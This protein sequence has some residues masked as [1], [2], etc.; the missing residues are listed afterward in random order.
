MKRTTLFVMLMF[1]ALVLHSQISLTQDFDNGDQ[2]WETNTFF[3]ISINPCSGVSARK[4]I[5]SPATSGDMTSPNLVGLSNGN[6]VTV[7][8][9][10]KIVDWGLGTVATQPGWGDFE[11]Q[12]STDDG[13][14]WITVVTI[15]DSNHIT[16]NQCANISYNISGSSLPVG[17]DFKFRINATYAD[18]DYF[19]YI[20]NIVIS[21]AGNQSPPVNDDVQDAISLDVGA[22][23]DDFKIDGSVLGATM[24]SE[25]AGC[26][27]DG[28]GVWYKTIVPSDGAVLIETG[29]HSSN[30][31]GFDSVIEVFSGSIGSLVSI[32]CNDE[33]DNT[34]A[35][36]SQLELTSLTPGETVYIRVWEDG[37]NETEPFAISAYAA[38]L[39]TDEFT[40]DD[41]NLYPNPMKDF[42]KVNA[43]TT[44]DSLTIYDVLGKK[45]RQ[46]N[47]INP[48]TE[49]DI[50]NLKSGAYIAVVTSEESTKI[51]R[52]IKQ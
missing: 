49:I 25:V 39:S 43:V 19:L 33:S 16:S 36:F 22:E 44:L 31:S 47:D 27:V 6:D 34:E 38:T 20:D 42:I 46:L 45:V 32:G 35:N 2:G 5:F 3:F 30:N 9:D 48:D 51:L 4:S 37:G 11:I 50:S 15:D 10:Y 8:L 14:N 41:I 29:T 13:S 12:Y 26:G 28:P 7:S 23:Y 40:F 17:S 1:S 18:G 24:D 21:Q 52:L